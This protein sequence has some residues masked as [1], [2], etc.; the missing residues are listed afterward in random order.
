MKRQ[1]FYAVVW[2]ENMKIITFKNGVEIY[3]TR[4]MAEEARDAWG[5]PKT[6]VVE[7]EIGILYKP[8]KFC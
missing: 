8:K 6:K 4:W 5:K 1:R 3:P 7:L 2:K